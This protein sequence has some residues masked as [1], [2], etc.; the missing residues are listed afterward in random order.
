MVFNNR[1]ILFNLFRDAFLIRKT[2]CIIG[3]W[4]TKDNKGGITELFRPGFSKT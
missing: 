2:L 1:F 4:Y 3:Y